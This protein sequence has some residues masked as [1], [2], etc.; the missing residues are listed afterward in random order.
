MATAEKVKAPLPVAHVVRMRPALAEQI[1]NKAYARIPWP[2]SNGS[3]ILGAPS[4]LPLPLKLGDRIF[5]VEIEGART[6]RADLVS[7]AAKFD[8]GTLYVLRGYGFHQGKTDDDLIEIGYQSV[9]TSCAILEA[10]DGA[11]G[12]G[13]VG[14]MAPAPGAHVVG[15]EPGRVID[16]LIVVGS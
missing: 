6:G 9:P 4:L 11:A 2:C 1:L 5:L 14:V 7:V 16:D 13:P 3:G 8:D 10:L 15:T 12:R